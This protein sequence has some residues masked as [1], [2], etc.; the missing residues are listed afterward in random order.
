MFDALADV[1]EKSYGVWMRA[2]TRRR[3]YTMGSKW[4]RPGGIAP[5][6]TMVN[7]GRKM[8]KKS[9]EISYANIGNNPIR[10]GIVKDVNALLKI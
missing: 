10:I 6:A 9:V 3:N 1:V 2:D 7:N 5:A 4:L 8:D